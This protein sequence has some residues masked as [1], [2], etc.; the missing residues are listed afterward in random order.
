MSRSEQMQVV[1]VAK[2]VCILAV[3]SQEEGRISN[4]LGTYSIHSCTLE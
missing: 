1:S 2:H 4:S 3:E